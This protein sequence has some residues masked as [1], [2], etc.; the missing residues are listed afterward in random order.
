MRLNA[1]YH[2]NNFKHSFPISFVCT[3]GTH[4][5]IHRLRRALFLNVW[6]ELVSLN[7]NL[8]PF[9][10]Y[11]EIS[12]MVNNRYHG[13]TLN[14]IEEFTRILV[15]VVFRAWLHNHSRVIVSCLCARCTSRHRHTHTHLHIIRA[16]NMRDNDD[17]TLSVHTH[18]YANCHANAFDYSNFIFFH[19]HQ[20]MQLE[21]FF[22]I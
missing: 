19:N 15:A 7:L 8:V 22:R 9:R 18:I 2:F 1:E 17:Y 5:E 11:I 10:S 6:M 3:H 4:T 12:L 20:F 14:R 16:A 21:N 13:S